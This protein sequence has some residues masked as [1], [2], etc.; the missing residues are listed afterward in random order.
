METGT[1]PDIGLQDY[2][3]KNFV[4]LK[5]QSGID[6]EQFLRFNVKGT[7]TFI[8]IDSEGDEIYRKI[9]FF[10]PGPLIEQLEKAREKF[11]H[12]EH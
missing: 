6:A 4:N 11:T 2:L 10:E 7:P 3:K 12:H 9:G 8:V 5:F 1:F